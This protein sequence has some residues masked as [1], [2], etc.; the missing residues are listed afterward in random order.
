[1][2]RPPHYCWGVLWFPS[3]E[4]IHK[5]MQAVAKRPGLPNVWPTM[6]ELKLYLQ[7]Q[8]VKSDV[9]EWVYNGWTHNHRVT[10]VFVFCPNWTILIAFFNVPGAVQYSQIAHWGKIYDKLDEVYKSMGGKCTADS[11][12]V[13]VNPPFLIKSSQDILVSS[14]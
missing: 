7:Q 12:F 11:P 2:I 1:M 4:K 9:Q 14:A 8:S 3:E 13:K 6:E 10:S 5:Y